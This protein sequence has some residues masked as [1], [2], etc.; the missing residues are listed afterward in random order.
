MR[1][2][3]WLAA[4]ASVFG[5]ATL[6]AP[7]PA[8]AQS[9]QTRVQDPYCAQSKQNRTLAGAAIGGVAGAVL[10]RE[11]AARNARTEGTVLGGVAGAAAGAAIGRSTARCNTQVYNDNGYNNG[12]GHDGYGRQTS[13]PNNGGYGD[14]SGLY[15][16]RTDSRN[17]RW[18]STTT[19][20][21]DG[22]EVR[23]SVYM[24][25]GRDGV[26]RRAN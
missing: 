15:G 4:A 18:G 13:Y 6:G 7:A 8:A 16:G 23:E 22:R 17:C 5:L 3:L 19:R 10:G 25:R 24:C 14:D 21:P 2:A 20:D 9:Y 26:W 11:V 1:N 12:Y